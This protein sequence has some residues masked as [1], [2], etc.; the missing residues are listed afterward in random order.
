MPQTQSNENFTQNLIRAFTQRG[1][2]GP[3]NAVRPAGVDEQY[4]MVG[5]IS[6]PDRGGITAINVNNPR[7]RGTFLRTGITIDAPDIP[8]NTVTF[9][10]KIGGVP[11]YR[12]KLNCPINIYETEAPCN[13]PADP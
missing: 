4:L 6:V 1:G 7:Q 2:P 12:F 3:N 9:K 5:D 8:S 11:W 10:Q 13:D